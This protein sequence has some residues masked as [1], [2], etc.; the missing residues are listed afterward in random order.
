MTENDTLATRLTSSETGQ[1]A[2][3]WLPLMKLLAQGDPVEI[4]TLATVTGRS[5]ADVR[6]A[7]AAVP[8]IEYE[9][10]RIIGQGLTLRPTPHRFEVN[11]EQLY[12]WCALDTLIF[13]TLLDASARV[14]SVSPTT[15]EPI[16][17]TVGP[18]GVQSVS[19]ETAVVSL[20]NPSDMTSVRSAFCNQVHYFTSA[21]DAQTWLET[22]PGGEV[23]PVTEAYALGTQMAR[24]M[25]ENAQEVGRP[26]R[27]DSCC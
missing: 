20:V 5:E 8:D 7:L 21:G 1:E 23:M 24:T 14:E 16:T 18:R 11:G 2:S 4:S 9:Y 17:I 13:P 3:L 27:A 15:G 12:T 26:S 6:Q 25:I 19:P 10:G 22:H